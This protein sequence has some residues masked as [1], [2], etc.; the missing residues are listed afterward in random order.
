MGVGNGRSQGTQSST[1][2]AQHPA[3]WHPQAQTDTD[4]RHAKKSPTLRPRTGAP[5]LGDRRRCAETRAKLGWGKLLLIPL[6]C[7]GS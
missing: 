5:W 3:P 6:P 1:A 2:V 4:S 7:W